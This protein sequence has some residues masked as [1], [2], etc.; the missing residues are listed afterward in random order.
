MKD[1]VLFGFFSL[2]VHPER[3]WFRVEFVDGS[4]Q[5]AHRLQRSF[6]VLTGALIH[7]RWCQVWSDPANLEYH[8]EI[9][10]SP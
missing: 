4:Q 1:T 9:C 5:T 10:R 7:S 6:R 2:P 3:M 8:Y